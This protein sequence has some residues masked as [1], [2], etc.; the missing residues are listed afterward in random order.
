V[1][2]VVDTNVLVGSLLRGQGFSRRII[3]DCLKG[4][5]SPQISNALYYEYEDVFGRQ[6]IFEN[7][8]TTIDERE[9]I[10][11]SFLEICDWKNVKYNWRPNL[12]NENDNHLI[13]LA[14]VSNANAI[15]T[16]NKK[17]FANSDLHF[18]QISIL[19]PKEFFE[20]WSV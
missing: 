10:F 17:D 2:I 13:E 7:S 16:F 19:N 11:K 3:L 5:L 6:N 18:P 12:Q 15:V 14:I 8:S 20:H 1:K 9:I 4:K